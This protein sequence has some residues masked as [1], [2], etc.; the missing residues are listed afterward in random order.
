MHLKSPDWSAGSGIERH[1]M[2]AGLSAEEIS[3]LMAA[4]TRS[5]PAEAMQLLRRHRAALLQSIHEAQ[6]RLY[7]LDLL[8]RTISTKGDDHD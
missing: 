2:D 4:L 6:E 8:L 7:C 5:C 1:A 3:R